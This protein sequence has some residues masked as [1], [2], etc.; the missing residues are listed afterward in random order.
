MGSRRFAVL[1]SR[2]LAAAALGLAAACADGMA[3]GVVPEGRYGYEASHPTPDGGSI[4][5]AGVMV[6]T[7]SDVNSVSGLWEVPDLHP[8]MD[9]GDR[10]GEAYEV[11]AHPTY[12]GTLTHRI[13]REGDAI[14]CEGEYTWIAEGGIERTAPVTCSIS[15]E[16]GERPAMPPRGP[17]DPIVR[18]I[19]ADTLPPPGLSPDDAPGP[20][21]D[22]A[23]A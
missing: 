23:G 11:M 8:E 10:E 15:P 12:F 7:E 1:A 18:P 21:P 4:D 22:T 5:L 6:I 17:E 3:E 19:D 9:L 20:R 14:L 13:W 16:A 2:S